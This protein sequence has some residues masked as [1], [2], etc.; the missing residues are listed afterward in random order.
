MRITEFVQCTDFPCVE[1]RQESYYVPDLEVDPSSIRL[2]LI[3]ETAATISSDNYY[4]GNDA[5][6]ASTTLQAFREAGLN[7]CS[8]PEL[9]HHGVYL[10]TAVK[11]GKYDYAVA[12]TTIAHCSVL[13]ERELAHFPEVNAYLLMGYVA[14]K[15][16]NTIARRQGEP[17]PIP[18]GSTYK[19]RGGVFTYRGKRVFP[20]YLQAGPSFG[21]EKS[22]QRMIA[23]DIANAIKGTGLEGMST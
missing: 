14:I 5:M 16:F 9:L 1:A 15:V 22:K 23:Q 3:S 20:S 21:I 2:M 18:A 10:T 12:T 8:I 4:A 19:I 11:C 13:L 6:F 7:A 17:R